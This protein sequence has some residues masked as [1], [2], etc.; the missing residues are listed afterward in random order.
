M[1][2]RPKLRLTREYYAFLILVAAL[3]LGVVMFFIVNVGLNSAREQQ[4]C[5]DEMTS[6]YIQEEGYEYDSA[7]HL[8]IEN[9]D[10]IRDNE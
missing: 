7:R 4:A 10:W 6:Y 5:Y 9:C 3:V 8:A 2:T 1:V